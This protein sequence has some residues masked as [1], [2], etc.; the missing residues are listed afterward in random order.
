[1][2]NAVPGSLQVFGK[3]ARVARTYTTGGAHVCSPSW[4]GASV[5]DITEVEGHSRLLTM[6]SGSYARVLAVEERGSQVDLYAQDDQVASGSRYSA[7]SAEPGTGSDDDPER[8][9]SCRQAA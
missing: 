4:R 3:E 5:G 2:K 1:M 8:R 9:C 6:A 7:K